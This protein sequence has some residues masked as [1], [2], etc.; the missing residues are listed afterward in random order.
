MDLPIN[1]FKRALKAGRQQIGLWSSLSSN[2]TVEILAG[3]GFDWLLLDT[4]HAPNELPMVYSQLQA[5]ASGGTAHPVVRLP[6][7]DAV[8]I[9]RFLDAGAQSLLLPMVETEEEAKRAVAATRYPPDGIR[10]FAGAARASRFGRVKNY[11]A[12]AHE[13]ICVLVQ[14]ETGRG[15]ENLEAIASVDGIDGVFMGPGDLSAALGF[16][17]QQG[18]PK[19]VEEIENAIRRIRTCGNAPGILTSDETLARRYIAAGCLFT[20]VGAD[21]GILARGAEALAAK[22]QLKN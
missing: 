14:V 9:K 2:I 17:G 18:H 4:E 11:H 22:F 15:L 20:A 13:E 1:S 19:M 16:L 10:G 3:A 12:R 6:W 8:V 7:N 21:L 5:A